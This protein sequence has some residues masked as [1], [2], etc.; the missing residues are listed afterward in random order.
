MKL[1]KFVSY[2]IINQSQKLVT[3]KFPLNLNSV[4][5]IYSGRL[6]AIDIHFPDHTRKKLDLRHADLPEHAYAFLFE[7]SPALEVLYANN[8]IGDY[9]LD[10][11]SHFARICARSG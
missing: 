1:E 5:F 7:N 11:L 2:A 6:D 10:A 3:L 8:H 9:G 4:S